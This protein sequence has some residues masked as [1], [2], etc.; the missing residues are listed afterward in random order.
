MVADRRGPRPVPGAHSL[1]ECLRIG[2]VGAGILRQGRSDKF[3]VDEV[4]RVQDRKAGKAVEGGCRHVVVFSDPADIR[5][6]VIGVE[7]RVG[8]ALRTE[9]QGGQAGYDQ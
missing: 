7:D 2:S 9:G 8:I 5:I 1:P 6:A 4:P 3:P